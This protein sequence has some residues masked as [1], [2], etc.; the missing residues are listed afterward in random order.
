MADISKILLRP[1]EQ[2]NGSQKALAAALEAEG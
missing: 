1:C 2:T